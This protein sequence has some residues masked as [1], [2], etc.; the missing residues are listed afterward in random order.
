MSYLF[1][2]DDAIGFARTLGAE[3]REHGDELFFRY[4]PKCHGGGSR[5]KD[6]FSINLKSGVFKCFRASCDYHGHFVE[7][8]RDFDYDLGLGEKR[9]YR[10]LPQKPVVVRDGAI[11]YMAQRGIS[12]E[13]CRRYELTTR[14][15]NKNILV[16]PF[17][18]E[19]GTLQFVKYRNMKFRKGI[20]KNKEW[21]EADAMPILFG[22]K[23]CNGFDRLIITEG[24]IDSLSV[25]ECGFDNAVSV[26]TGALGFT[27]LANCWDWITKFQEIVVFGDNEHGKITLADALRSRL[28]QTIKVVRRKDYLGEKD[29]NDIL[30]KYGREA[31][32]TAVNNAEVPRLENVKDLSTVESIDLNS[33]QKIKTNIPEIDRI[34]GGLVMSQV[35]LLTGRR[36]EGKSTFMSQL[37]CEAL[38]QGESVFIYSGELADYHFKRWLDYQ[39]AGTANVQS[40]LNLYGDYEYSITKSTLERI[41]S[42]YRGRAYIYDNSWIPD[43]IGELESLP[44]TIEKVIRQYGVR[45]I[46]ID[47]LMTAMETVSDNSQLNLAQSNFVGQLKRIAAKFDVVIILVAHPRK[48]KDDFSND[49][50]AGSADITNKAD[51]VMSYQRSKEDDCNSRLQITKNRLFGKYAVKEDAIKLMYSEKTKRIFSVDGDRHYGWESI[52]YEIQ[53]EEL[54]L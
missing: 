46:C 14:T 12:A 51:V 25:A 37:V 53:E 9:V 50:V 17:Y 21:S 29:A 6:T 31:I 27:W 45:M 7:L 16:F 26:P 32:K 20:D 44:E 35:I 15:D 54:P 4:C 3:T 18:D 36:G 39:L 48:T 47:N 1:S 24:Q 52:S 30:C 19:A 11:Q 40:R 2:R 41:S 22:M 49:D 10:K 8:A 13:I 42:W 43:D 34:I 23:Q 28:T 38:E 5:D 33:L